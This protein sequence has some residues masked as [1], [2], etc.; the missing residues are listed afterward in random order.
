MAW[1]WSDEF[2]EIV[3]DESSTASWR[4]SLVGFAVPEGETRV[5]FVRRLVGA[6]EPAALLEVVPDGCGAAGCRLAES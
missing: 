4:G 6:P 2:A 1:V 5:S 3:P